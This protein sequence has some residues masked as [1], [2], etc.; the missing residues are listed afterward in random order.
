MPAGLK[1]FGLRVRHPGVLIYFSDS[2][3]IG[4]EAALSKTIRAIVHAE[5]AK[6]AQSVGTLACA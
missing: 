2:K 3:K 4:L 6:V 1:K 5:T